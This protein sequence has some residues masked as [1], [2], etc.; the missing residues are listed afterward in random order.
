M[1]NRGPSL[2]EYKK[3]LEDCF[4][5]NPW[6]YWTDFLFTAVVGWGAFIET[7]RLPAFSLAQI[8]FFLISVFALYRGVLFIHELTHRER[9]DLPGFSIAWN[10]VFGIP[11]LF[12]SFMYRGVHI[13]HH[14][15]NSYG[16]EEDGEYLPLGASPFWKTAVY[17]GQSFL[18]PI[19]VLFRFG[20]L[21]PFS[22]VH[23][24]LRHFVMAR[25]SSLAIR[26]D[27][28]RKIPGGIDLR[29]WYILEALCFFYFVAVAGFFVTGTLSLD[30]LFHIYLTMVT[31]FFIN[32]I[33]T[34]VAHR[35][36]NRAGKEISFQDQ[37]LDSV[38]IEGNSVVAEL[39]APVGLRYH[40]LHHLFPTLPYHNL[41]I[42]HRRLRARLPADS[43]Y[44]Q[45]VE[46]SFWAAL[47]THWN[48][49][50]HLSEETM[51][52]SAEA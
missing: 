10:L 45:T 2:A 43:F 5:A 41:G 42:A 14:K 8:T 46:P 25:N 11:T 6:I 40:A 48:N 9:T 30:T 44:H 15:K 1:K 19:L 26:F 23:P 36:R 52:G 34:I 49:T 31:L 35:Y 21:A 32:S 12:P 13:D 27:T 16:T 29:N 20:I 33:R 22:L 24:R 7:E 38:N 37:L 50:H 17:M 39:L 18:L 3:L 4:P 51:A 28:V 47:V